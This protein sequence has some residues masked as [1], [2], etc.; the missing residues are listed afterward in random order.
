MHAGGASNFFCP[1]HIVCEREGY[2]PKELDAEF[3]LAE[4]YNNSLTQN[5]VTLT[6]P[7]DPNAPKFPD[8]DYETLL[9]VTDAMATIVI[10]AINVNLPVHQIA[11]GK[12]V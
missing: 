11:S 1:A 2:Q 12:L 3:A 6:D 4:K 8:G 10:P 5:R 7:F 9:D